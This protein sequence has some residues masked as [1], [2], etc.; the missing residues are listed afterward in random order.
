MNSIAFIY[1]IKNKKNYSNILLLFFIYVLNCTLFMGMFYYEYKLNL[2]LDEK[3]TAR[4]IVEDKDV[5]NKNFLNIKECPDYIQNECILS[6][7][8]YNKDKIINYLEKENIEYYLSTEVEKLIH[9]T[10][11]KYLL[12]VGLSVISLLLYFIC[13]NIMK[14]KLNKDKNTKYVLKALGAKN[15]TIIIFDYAYMIPLFIIY[16]LLVLILT[17]L[18]SILV[19]FDFFKAYIMYIFISYMFVILIYFI[20]YNVLL[21]KNLQELAYDKW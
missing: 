1:F 14:N 4:V 20:S 15:K 3:M 7:N 2:A 16:L 13:I 17:L 12:I 9:F 6:I 19:D 11:I 8:R 10:R 18:F 5:L 21:F